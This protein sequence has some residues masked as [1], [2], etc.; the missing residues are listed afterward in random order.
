M[1]K[2]V[3]IEY[4][5]IGECG[6]QAWDIE[7]KGLSAVELAN[8]ICCLIRKLQ[9]ATNTEYANTLLKFAFDNVL[10]DNEYEGHIEINQ[11]VD[12]STVI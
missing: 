9:D 10:N 7:T 4:A 1:K 2:G 5:G 6:F 3:I 11:A 8:I 12:K